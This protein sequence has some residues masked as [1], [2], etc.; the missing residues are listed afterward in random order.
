[1]LGQVR[2]LLAQELT[3]SGVDKLVSTSAQYPEVVI[4]ELLQA[5]ES[6]PLTETR[7]KDRARRLA[8]VIS[9]TGGRASVDAL[10]NLLDRNQA[11]YGRSFIR[12]LDYSRGRS[13][14]FALV[15]E[16]LQRSN[17]DLTNA[18]VDWVASAVDRGGPDEESFAKQVMSR[19][20]GRPSAA[21][22]SADSLVKLLPREVVS[23]VK[24][25]INAITARQGGR[26]GIDR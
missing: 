4:P 14:S 13:N 7:D 17:D 12:M 16:A 10:F 9:Y 22:L 21:D 6:R 2:D 19:Y 23:R 15:Y 26:V 25:R 3:D 5:I 20:G 18:L 1:V 11:M 24:D 8:D